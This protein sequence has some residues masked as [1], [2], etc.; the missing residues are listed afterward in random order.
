MQGTPSTAPNTDSAIKKA[1]TLG[2][3]KGMTIASLNVNSLLID[4]IRML[5]NEL[6][7]HILAINETRQ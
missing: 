6:G 4:A 2:H 7:I 1:A 5:V 3:R